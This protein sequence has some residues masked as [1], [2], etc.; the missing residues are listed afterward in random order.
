MK[1]LTAQEEFNI[2]GIIR[3]P[4]FS[5]IDST[6]TNRKRVSYS[7]LARKEG[8]VLLI[9]SS[10]FLIDSVFAGI[11][12]RHIEYIAK[13]GPKNYKEN[14]FKIL[15][16]K[17]MLHGVS[18]IIQALD[19]E[20]GENATQNRERINNVIRYIKDNRIVFEF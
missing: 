2:Q 15:Q 8:D 1:D 13:N 19:K 5:Y 17:E 20:L 7:V 6:L 11:T 16:D 18:E 9:D 4:H 14:L 10:G 12:E 3:E